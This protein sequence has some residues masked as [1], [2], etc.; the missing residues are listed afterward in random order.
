[1]LLNCVA[2]VYKPDRSEKPPILNRGLKRIA[3]RKQA[4][5][6]EPCFS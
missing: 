5:D 2:K 1:M 6:T 3:G 4:K